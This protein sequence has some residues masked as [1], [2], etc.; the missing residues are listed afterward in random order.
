MQKCDNNFLM[1][2]R[3]V[4]IV[5][6]WLALAFIS[7]NVALRS[8]SAQ[9]NAGAETGVFH[10]DNLE[11]TV[12]AGFSK[13]EVNNWMGSWI[14]FRITLVNQGPPINGRLIVHCESSGN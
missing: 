6:L 2:G 14:P 12:K 4:A 10:T 3:G 5:A 13:L 9:E 11:M 8:A 1:T 7:F